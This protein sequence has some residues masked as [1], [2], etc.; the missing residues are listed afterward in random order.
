MTANGNDRRFGRRQ[1]VKATGAVLGAGA[2]FPHLVFRPG[3]AAAQDAPLGKI[4]APDVQKYT[5]TTIN[6][7]V[8][9][10]TATDAIQQLSSNFEQ[11]TGIKVNFEQI[12]QQQM[13]QK[14]RTD[15]ATGTGSYDVMGWFLNPEYVENDWVRPIDE[16]RQDAGSTD[17]AL[18]AIDDFYPPFL[19]WNQ[20]KGVLYSLPFYGESIMM[21]YNT[22]EFERAGIA[23]APE[24]VEEL[25]EAC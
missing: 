13:D 22:E 21:Y 12:P 17:E 6:L 20:Y 25:E 5:G 11:Q 3:A 9:K 1:F 4:T 18:L 15:L 2:A 23:Q 16:M 19:G 24:T 8:Q 14:Q 7:A 10:H